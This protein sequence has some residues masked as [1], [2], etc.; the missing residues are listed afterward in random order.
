M[1]AYR[2]LS[3]SVLRWDRDVDLMAEL[4]KAGFGKVAAQRLSFGIAT[5]YIARK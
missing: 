5:V 2:Y 1:K 3:R 4:M